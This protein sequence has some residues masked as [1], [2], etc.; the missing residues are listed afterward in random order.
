MTERTYRLLVGLLIVTFLFF[1]LN[2][3]LW[4]LM[5]LMSLEALTNCRIPILVTRLLYPKDVIKISSGENPN[6]RI[7]YEAERMLRWICMSLILIGTANYTEDMLW[8]LPWLV[9]LML[10]ISGVTGICPVVMALRKA[11]LK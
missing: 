1:N 9:G 8:Y 7:N 11:G 4:T 3:A 2:Y 10:L 6:Y 5:V